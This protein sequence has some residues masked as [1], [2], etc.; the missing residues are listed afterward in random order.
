MFNIK[1]SAKASIE[2]DEIFE[3]ILE[4]N[5]F[6]A[7]KV[8]NNIAKTIKNIVIFPYMWKKTWSYREFVETKYK[9]RIIYKI[10]EEKQLIIIVSIFKNTNNF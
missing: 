9:Y 1:Y 5:N 8:I 6:F 10:E 4:D 3:Y 2:L 7:V